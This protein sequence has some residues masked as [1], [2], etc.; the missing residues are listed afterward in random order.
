VGEFAALMTSVCWSFSAVIFTYAGRRIGA[1]A[2]NRLR[3]LFALLFLI[4]S[5]FLARGTLIP[6]DASW[7]R[8][9]WLGLSGIAG[10]TLG[11]LALFQAYLYIG[12]RIG[13]LIMAIVPVFS[14][15]L[16]WLFLGELL[17]WT[18]ITGILLAVA[19]IAVVVMDHRG[20]STGIAH[21]RRQ[22][23]LGI[24]F[25][26]LAAIGQTTGL[27]LTKHGLE[28][29]YPAVSGVVIRVLVAALALWIA[30]LFSRQ[31][32]PTLTSLNQRSTAGLVV[33]GSLIGPFAGVWL[34]TIAVQLS[35][36]GVASTLTSLTPIL[37]LPISGWLFHEKISIRAVLGTLLTIAGVVILFLL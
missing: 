22:Y 7:D 20:G 6:L 1:G 28:G 33:A 18:Q 19:G 3:L 15:I 12:P 9:L 8:W 5:H 11:D 29:G 16:A 21:D 14:A 2:L 35:A 27:I 31:V 13:A 37:L 23:T 10:L 25:G 24:L 4:V 32:R 36:V 34:S 30:A 17:S 26:F